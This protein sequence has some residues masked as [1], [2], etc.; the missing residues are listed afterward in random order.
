MYSYKCRV[1]G[2]FL[3]PGEGSLCEECHMKV[4]RDREKKLQMERLTR[5]IGYTQMRIDDFA[6]QK[7][8]LKG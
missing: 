8:A 4:I 2:C 3:D 5:V 6:D 7:F 1:C